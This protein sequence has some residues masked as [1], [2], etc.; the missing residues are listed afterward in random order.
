MLLC[1][2]A[3]ARPASGQPGERDPERSP[4][5]ERRP[6]ELTLQQAVVRALSD[7]PAIAA[8][9]ARLGEARGRVTEAGVYP[10]NPV[11]RGQLGQRRGPGRTSVD[12]YTLL[13]Q[14][15]EI[16]GQRGD[17]LDSARADLDAEQAR[18]LRTRRLRAAKV[19]IAFI[20]ALEARDL[21]AVANKDRQ[22]TGRLYDLAKRRLSRGAGTQLD[23]NVAAAELGRSEA[24]HQAAEARYRTKRAALAEVIGLD[25]T[26]APLPRGDL[27]AQLDALPPLAGMLD[28]ARRHRADLQELRHAERA[29]RARE[30]L[31]R[32]EAW[33]D[34]EVRAFVRHMAQDTV[35]G[36]GLLVPLPLFNRNQGRIETSHAAARRV[37]A[38]RASGRLSVE[39]E[40]VAAHARYEAGARTAARLRKLVLGTLG[41]NIELLQRSFEAGKATWPEVV[42]IRRSLIDAERELTGAEAN[43][44][45]SWVE[46]QLAAGRIPLPR[47]AGRQEE[48]R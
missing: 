20:A 15:L 33:P 12:V 37:Q 45:R 41:Q 27:H 2:S 13:F 38:H 25:P 30:E 42:V 19:H 31:A 43:A 23:V 3:L 34:V 16:A 10:Y 26:T 21:L 35:M 6:L 46:L 8:A 9:E 4:P 1:A 48:G 24:R 17:R 18:L 14:R 47:R 36:G 44:R 7:S 40:V 5:R 32:S 29:S 28:S 11:L 22:L 39:R